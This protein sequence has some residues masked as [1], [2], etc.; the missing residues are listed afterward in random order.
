MQDQTPRE[1]PER[2][3]WEAQARDV[4]QEHFEANTDYDLNLEQIFEQHP[5]HTGGRA[6]LFSFQ[7]FLP[8]KPDRFFVF[9]GTTMPMI[10][11][12]MDLTTEDLW[13]VHIGMEYFV[14]NQV[15][16]EIKRSPKVL[17]Y[18]KMVATVFAEQLYITLNSTPTIEK[19][20]VVADQTHVVG[21][22][23]Y[24]EKVYSWI[25]GDIPHFVYKKDLP[26]QIIWAL[27]L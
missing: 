10:Y 16:E 11:P 27:H 25:V 14:N 4:V 3:E 21:K 6:A 17:A 5:L 19:I 2:A 7:P 24:E 12:E 20:Y 8:D 13:A 22:V 15:Q 23:T 9:S 26:P 18:L 1:A